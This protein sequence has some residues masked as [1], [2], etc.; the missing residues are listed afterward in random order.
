M[1][2]FNNFNPLPILLI[3]S[4][5]FQKWKC[6]AIALQSTLGKSYQN[7]K[8]SQS[9]TIKKKPQE[10]KNDIIE[11]KFEKMN[12]PN[13]EKKKYDSKAANFNKE[14]KE[15]EEEKKEEYPSFPCIKKI[16][17]NFISND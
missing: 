17:N 1:I 11:Y 14:K 9:R 4:L 2:N 3:S 7:K 6:H 8:I 16:E 5:L 10:F 15:E 12:I 13:V